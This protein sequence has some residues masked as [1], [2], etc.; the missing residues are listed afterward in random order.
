MDK[1]SGFLLSTAEAAKY[2]GL[3]TNYLEKLRIT[4]GGPAFVKISG[5][6]SGMVRY[7][8]D[9]IDAWVLAS[10]RCSTSDTG[11]AA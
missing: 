2:L 3:T 11:R 1:K 5:G 7:I 10:R 4:G 6:P 9:D 8:R